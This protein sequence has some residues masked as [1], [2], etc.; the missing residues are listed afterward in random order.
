M[1]YK[2]IA[3][4]LVVISGIAIIA[5]TITDSYSF[6]TAQR[7]FPQVF[8]PAATSAAANTENPAPMPDGAQAQQE[9]L[10]NQMQKAV[11]Q[12]L[13]SILPAESIF[14]MLNAVCW[15]VFASFLVFAGAKLAEVGVKLLADAKTTAPGA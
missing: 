15:S 13:A 4:W 7:D 8:K 14:K 12:S 2:K 5:T 11:N 10:Q 3:G 6:F 9:Y 1:Q